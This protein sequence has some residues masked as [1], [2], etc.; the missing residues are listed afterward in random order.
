[1]QI[2]D[3][4]IHFLYQ[5]WRSGSMRAASEILEM[6]PS[7]ISRQIARLEHEVGSTLIEHGRRDS[8]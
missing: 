8:C 3:G 5:A 2:N 7:S 6:A 1:M 4:R